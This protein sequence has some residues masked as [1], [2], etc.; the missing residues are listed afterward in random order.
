MLL[1]R[2]QRDRLGAD[3]LHDPL[4]RAPLVE[5]EAY[6]GMARNGPR[7]HSFRRVE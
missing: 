3:E 7:R 5:V 4:C 2:G 1:T 6:R